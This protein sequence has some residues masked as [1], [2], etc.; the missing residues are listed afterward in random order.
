M[1]FGLGLHQGALVQAQIMVY[2]TTTHGVMLL[3]KREDFRKRIFASRLS[4]ELQ[5]SKMLSKESGF[6]RGPQVIT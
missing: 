1:I 3:R 5:K 6:V 2:S 4:L